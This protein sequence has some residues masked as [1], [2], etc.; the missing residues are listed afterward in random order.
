MSRCPSI[1]RVMMSNSSM[2]TPMPR[3]TG[4]LVLTGK[5]GRNSSHVF[6]LETSV[7]AKER[8]VHLVPADAAAPLIRRAPQDRAGQWGSKHQPAGAP[9]CPG[10]RLPAQVSV[11]LPR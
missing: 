1:T 11:S 10:E 9:P 8:S 6:F 4:V 2:D 5:R 3:T 7:E